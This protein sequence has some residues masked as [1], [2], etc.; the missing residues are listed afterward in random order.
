MQVIFLST[1]TL[2]IQKKCDGHESDRDKNHGKNNVQVSTLI[3][4]F[5]PN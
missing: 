2:L 1:S 5:D 3:M 4:C